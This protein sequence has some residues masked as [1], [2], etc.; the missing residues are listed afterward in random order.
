MTE[1]CDNWY[2]IDG[3]TQYFMGETNG[4][5]PVIGVDKGG[6]VL[7]DTGPPGSYDQMRTGLKELGFSVEDI[8]T[9]IITHYHF[10]HVGNLHN[11]LHD[12]KKTTVYMGM[13]DILYYDGVKSPDPIPPDMEEINQYFPEATKE[14]LDEMFSEVSLEPEKIDIHNLK[15]LSGQTTHFTEAGGFDVIQ[16][17]GHTPGHLSVYIPSSKVMIPGDLMMYWKGRF[18]GPVK[19]FSANF[20]EAVGSLKKISALQ[21]RKLIGYH[22]SPFYGDVNGLVEEYLRS[23]DL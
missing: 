3:V 6:I 20:K 11:F 12:N 4:I 10:D 1:I 9:I 18:S 23:V 2:V 8:Q 14:T 16:T 15:P 7:I 19:T 22:G 17:P 21:M 13:N 5:S